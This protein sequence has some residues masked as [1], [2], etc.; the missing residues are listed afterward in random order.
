MTGQRFGLKV[1]GLLFAIFCVAHIV[2]LVSQVDIQI[3]GRVIPLWPSAVAAI[4]AA[5]LSIWF[6]TLARRTGP[7]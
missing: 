4:F 5:A 7:P 6:L 2:R 3:A 1:A